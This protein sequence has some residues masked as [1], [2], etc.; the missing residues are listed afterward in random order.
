MSRRKKEPQAGEVWSSVRRVKG[1]RKLVSR[2]TTFHS[3]GAMAASISDVLDGQGIQFL[4]LDHAE[5]IEVAED[6][7]RLAASIRRWKGDPQ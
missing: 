7:E 6:L 5:W 4:F 2:V 3:R 1:N